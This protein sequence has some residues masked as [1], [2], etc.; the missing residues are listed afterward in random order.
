MI[1]RCSASLEPAVESTYLS[2]PKI[3]HR[4][5]A[6]VELGGG[7]LGGGEGLRS[8]VVAKGEGAVE[9]EQQQQQR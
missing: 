9:K 7:G 1:S 8:A 3:D 4:R 2:K 5:L 6:D